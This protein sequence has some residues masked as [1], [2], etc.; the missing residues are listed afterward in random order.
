MRTLIAPSLLACDFANLER[1]VRRAEAAD[2]DML[3]CDIMD[4]HFVPNLT[5]GPPVI[6]GIRK[7]TTLHLDCHLMVDNAHLFFESFRKAGADAITIH[8]EVYPEPEPHLDRIAALGMKRG[9]C[10]NPD[11]PVER[12]KGHLDKV[13]RLLIMSVFPG[14]GGQ[15]FIEATYERLRAVVALG[16]RPEMEIQVD[17]GI[18]IENA[19]AVVDAGANNIVSGTG[20]FRAP[21]MASAVRMMRGSES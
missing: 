21:D 4:G 7:I 10:I 17:G 12:L 6:S 5:M 20:L 2:V 8:L 16:V 14:F 9:L 11:M 1:E 3:H 15:S 19:R 13:D 18:Y